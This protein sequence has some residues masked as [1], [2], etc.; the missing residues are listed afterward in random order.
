[1]I[2]LINKHPVPLIFKKIL[3]ENLSGELVIGTDD[4]VKRF[5]FIKGELEFASSDLPHE[6][7]GEILLS[8]GKINREQIIMFNKMRERTGEKFGKILVKHRILKKAELFTA[9]QDQVKIIGISSFSLTSGGWSFKKGTPRIPQDQKFGLPLASIIMEGVSRIT[10]FSYY[11]NRF[12]LR[13]PLTLPIPESLGQILSPDNIRLYLKLTR[14]DSISTKQIS[15]MLDLSENEFWQQLVMLYLLNIIDFT[16]FR[17][18]SEL[19][20]DLETLNELHDK[21]KADTID[22]YQLLQLKDTASINEVSDKY[23]TFTKKYNPGAIAVPPGSKAEEK[24][25]FVIEKAVEAY[26]T[27][28]DK[29][30]KEA[31]DTG[32]FKNEKIPAKEID[33]QS[34]P[35]KARELYLKAHTFYE[36]N[37]YYEAVRCMEEAVRLEDARASYYLLLG[38]SQMRIPE[39]RPSA[40]KSLQK[41]ADMEP[42]NA[43]PVFYLGQLY[44]SENLLKKAE[45]CFRK[46]L[47]INMEHTLAAK[48]IDKIEK[49]LKKK[50]FLPFQKK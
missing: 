45:R 9:L 25:D 39:Y 12:S 49:K 38:L 10:D 37:R 22:H 3:A 15:E 7:L 27:L 23:F 26:E 36:E 17:I 8:Q 29:D 34:N 31:Y 43:D 28:S 30:K 19:H 18:G 41:V 20:R 4:L 24:V 1:M 47:E 35:Q 5:Y 32:H 2:N 42:W 33:K 46:A 50:S 21:L 6:R 40:E 13:A 11:K 16:E 48:M 44:W 14:C